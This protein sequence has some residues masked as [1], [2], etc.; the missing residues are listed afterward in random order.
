MQSLPL[1]AYDGT[2]RSTHDRKILIRVEYCKDLDRG[3]F[4]IP[5]KIN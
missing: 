3:G 1:K 4:R 2:P 5:Y